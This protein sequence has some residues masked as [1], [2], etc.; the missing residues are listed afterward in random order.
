MDQLGLTASPDQTATEIS[1]CALAALHASGALFYWIENGEK[2]ADVS[3]AGISTSFYQS[4]ATEMEPVD[5]SNVLRMSAAG[6]KLTQLRRPDHPMRDYAEKYGQLLRRY[7]ITD[8]IDLMFWADGVP[9]AGIGVLKRQGDPPTCDATL[10]VA[11]AMQ[12]YMEFN[13]QNH[14]R[15]TQAR[16][17]RA[18]SQTFGLTSREISVSECVLQGLTNE[19]IATA[20]NI[21]LATVKSHLMQIFGKTGC[22]NRT[23]LAAILNASGTA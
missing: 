8:V 13:L 15:F 12:R 10:A 23:K 21:R 14:A 6:S 5:P 11:G 17:H 4:Y 22:G 7:Q 1:R 9:M 3:L 18:L 19:D 20:M 16:R 2:M